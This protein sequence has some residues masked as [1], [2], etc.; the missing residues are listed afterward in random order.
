[1]RPPIHLCLAAPALLLA[2]CGTTLEFAKPVPART[3]IGAQARVAVVPTDGFSGDVAD[4]L[5]REIAKSGHY[6]LSEGGVSGQQGATYLIRLANANLSTETNVTSYT[7]EDDNTYY[8][9]SYSVTGSLWGNIQTV[10]TGRLHSSLR[11]WSYDTEDSW[12]SAYDD[13]VRDI[14]TDLAHDLIPT[15]QRYT[16]TI[17]SVDNNPLVKEAAQFCKE[18]NW[19]YGKYVA[20]QAL[21]ATPED[22]EAN[23]LMGMIERHF[24]NFTSSE[25]YLR[26]AATLGDRAKYRVQLD[27]CKPW[28]DRTVLV[29]KQ[30]GRKR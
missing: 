25:K 16:V 28:K 12:D 30:L 22:P 26:K 27:N 5:R 2:S 13:V 10:S 9:Y 14:A 7:D 18:G 6:I 1:M 3:N 29:N 8:D 23:F 19:E 4:R 17:Q 21:E 24:E 11:Y 15:R 20:R